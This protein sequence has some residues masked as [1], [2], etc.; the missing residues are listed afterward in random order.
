MNKSIFYFLL[1]FFGLF[2]FGLLILQ[3]S[4]MPTVG[5]KFIL[6]CGFLGFGFSA[7][8]MLLNC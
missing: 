5:I 4:C 8:L 3:A 2:V 6:L 1:G 7:K